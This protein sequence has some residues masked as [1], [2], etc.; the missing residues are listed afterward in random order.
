MTEVTSTART[1][2]HSSG[3][4]LGLSIQRA[5]GERMPPAPGSDF[6]PSVSLKPASRE[7]DWAVH[8]NLDK[9]G[10]D[11]KMRSSFETER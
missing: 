6:H 9:R 11:H 7:G 1:K 4:H 2:Q 3:A 10:S 5:L 8:H